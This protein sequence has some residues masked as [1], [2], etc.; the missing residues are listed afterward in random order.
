MFNSRVDNLPV[1]HELLLTMKQARFNLM[2]R[3]SG[4]IL[5]ECEFEEMHTKSTEY[6]SKT[7]SN[8]DI[9]TLREA[10]VLMIPAH[11]EHCA[12]YGFLWMYGTG[13]KK[14]IA[15]FHDVI[16]YSDEDDDD[17]KDYN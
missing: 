2:Y 5:D 15:L 14:N 7:F 11:G 16:D 6:I 8:E 9:A 13:G 1:A 3:E 4:S 10:H 12:Q 17:A